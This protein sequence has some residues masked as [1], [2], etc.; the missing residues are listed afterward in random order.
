MNIPEAHDLTALVTG[1]GRGI[2]KAIADALTQAGYRVL[3]P[4]RE[5]M[6]LSSLESVTAYTTLPSHTRVD[7][8]VNNAGENPIC[9]IESLPY[10]IFERALRVNLSAPMLLMQAVLPHMRQQRW[11][12]IVNISSCYGS[13]S[14]PG[15]GA[16]G[17]AKS[18]L[19]SLTRTAAL[20]FARD[21]ILVNA[22]CPGFVETALTHKNNTPEQIGALCGQIP[23]GRLASPD[24]IATLVLFV[25]SPHNTY[26]T[27]QCINIDGGF[28][29][30]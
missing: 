22:I 9:E 7:I 21:N 26:I 23:L 25:A 5:E 24:E 8:L 19:N 2:G 18:G 15:R 3:K 6:D 16:Y 12:R 10:D 11:G 17:A 1:A 20:E 29:C 30:Q 4:S 27:G 28:L 14:R 13:V